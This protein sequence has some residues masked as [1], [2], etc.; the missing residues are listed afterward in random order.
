MVELV[1]MLPF[2][3]CSGLAT[4]LYYVRGE[5]PDTFFVV[6]LLIIGG[7]SLTNNFMGV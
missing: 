6:L 7:F 4:F 1:P 5:N 3:I 2:L